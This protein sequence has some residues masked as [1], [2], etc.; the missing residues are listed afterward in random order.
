MAL[1][2]GDGDIKSV[3]VCVGVSVGTVVIRRRLSYILSI[4]LITDMALMIY[5]T[6]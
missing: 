1:G 3:A 5:G 4:L 2:I 6:P